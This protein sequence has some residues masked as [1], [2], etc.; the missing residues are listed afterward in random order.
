MRETPVGKFFQNILR[1]S[2]IKL[3]NQLD[4]EWYTW[5]HI[6]S[7]HVIKKLVIR[8]PIYLACVFSTLI[9]RPAH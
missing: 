5:L 1:L 9:F 8:D 6:V 7:G 3:F 2:C 4:M